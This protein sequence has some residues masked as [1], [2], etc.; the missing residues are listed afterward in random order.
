MIKKIDQPLIIS[1]LIFVKMTIIVSITSF[2]SETSFASSTCKPI[3]SVSE[4]SD[5]PYDAFSQIENLFVARFDELSHQIV[6]HPTDPSKF[7]PIQNKLNTLLTT[8]ESLEYQFIDTGKVNPFKLNEIE[9]ELKALKEEVHQAASQDPSKILQADMQRAPLDLTKLKE[10]TSQIQPN[11]VYEV[12]T[13]DQK[14]MSVLFSQKIVNELFNSTDHVL[15]LSASRLLKQIAKGILGKNSMAQGI[16]PLHLDTSIYELR[17][18]GTNVGRLRLGGY[19]HNNI[20]HFVIW[21]NQSEHSSTKYT[22]NFRDSVITAR[23]LNG[24]SKIQLLLNH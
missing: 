8:F 9:L 2:Y 19:L 18:F 12:A 16:K 5:D 11:H 22:T 15:T 24:H 3:F 1:L 23:K 14:I 21:T 17:A 13:N 7:G 20:L 4:R 6:Q 10:K